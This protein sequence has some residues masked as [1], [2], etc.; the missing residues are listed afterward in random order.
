MVAYRK[1]LELIRGT[2]GP[3]TF[4]EGCP[5]GTPLN[6]IGYFNSYFDGDDVYNSWQG[7]YALFSSINANAFWNHVVAYVMPGEGIDVAPPMTVAEAERKRPRTSSR[8]PAPASS[9]W[10][11]SAPPSPKPGPW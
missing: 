10:P 2:I 3:R 4:V 6:G 8:S 9:P 1:R 11:G 5:A 7:M